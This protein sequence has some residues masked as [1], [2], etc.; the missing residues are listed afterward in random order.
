MGSRAEPRVP[1]PERRELAFALVLVRAYPVLRNRH[2]VVRPSARI[3][4]GRVGISLLRMTGLPRLH[5]TVV[6]VWI[7]ADV[8]RADG[9]DELGW[10][11]GEPG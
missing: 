5:R 8:R 1:S 3:Q 11:G 6:R 9:G 7:A 4:R 2:R 10:L